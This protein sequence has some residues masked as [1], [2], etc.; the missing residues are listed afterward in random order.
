MHIAKLGS[1]RPIGSLLAALLP[2]HRRDPVTGAVSSVYRTIPLVCRLSIGTASARSQPLHLYPPQNKCAGVTQI[3]SPS[4][5]SGIESLAIFS[6]THFGP[7]LGGENEKFFPPPPHPPSERAGFL[8]FPF[9]LFAFS[10]DLPELTLN[11]SRKAKQHSP[12]VVGSALPRRPHDCPRSISFCPI[13][14]GPISLAALCTDSVS[15]IR[16][17]RRSPHRFAFCP[18]R[19]R[20]T[21]PAQPG[22]RRRS[23]H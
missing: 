12:A 14:P 23:S 18:A 4:P 8:I 16:F 22:H 3:T 19:R 7:N 15:T 20:H 17:A 11:G 1:C 13:K 2:P 5:V 9:F 6:Q 21:R 10:P